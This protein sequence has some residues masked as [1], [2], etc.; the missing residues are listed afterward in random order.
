MSADCRCEYCLRNR[1]AIY[2][3][4]KRQY[5]LL[6]WGCFWGRYMRDKED[7]ANKDTA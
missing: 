4:W 2:Y 1:A 3:T 6:C 7:A 5:R